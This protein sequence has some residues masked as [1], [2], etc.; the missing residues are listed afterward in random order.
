MSNK[1]I[2]YFDF[3]RG[4]AIIAVVGIH[5]FSSYYSKMN[6]DTHLDYNYL[7][8]HLIQP[9]VPVFLAISG[10]F[11]ANKN[12]STISEYFSFIKSQIFR[13]YLPMLVW[14]LPLFLL[15]IK[16]NGLNVFNIGN[17]LFGGFSI[18]YYVILII[19]FYLLLPVLQK[20]AVTI[21]GLVAA[22]SIS[23][24]ST[25]LI[26]YIF[27]VKRL[28]IPLL[29]Y[30][31]PFPIHLI[32]FA[33]GL[34]AGKHEISTKLT[35]WCIVLAI[36]F[37][38]GSYLESFIISQTINTTP[39]TGIR[40]TGFF[41]CI[42]IIL[43]ALSLKDKFKSSNLTNY[44]CKIGNN[45]FGIYLIHMYVLS[46]FIRKLD[47]YWLFEI[48]IV[49]FISILVISTVRKISPSLSKKYLGF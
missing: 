34:Y 43:I 1:R 32:S 19:Q 30:A 16:S 18:Y 42:F 33:I 24:F 35:K 13:V 41:F 3:L 40:L 39:S 8:R 6:I 26:E 17:F 2:A 49:L 31:G 47:L 29:M 11:L 10:Y 37:F 45:S 4:I 48:P 27:F 7:L 46:L 9:A 15:A 23:L 28:T 5:S 44:I 38:L 25:L 20:T 12:V 36:I 22:L 14:S 21:N